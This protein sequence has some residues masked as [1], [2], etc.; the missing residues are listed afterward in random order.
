MG[1]HKDNFIDKNDNENG[2]NIHDGNDN[3]DY[4]CNNDS[5]NSHNT[6]EGHQTT[7]TDPSTKSHFHHNYQNKNE[8][9]PDNM[10]PP[11]ATATA[12]LV[13]ELEAQI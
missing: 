4:L 12:V 7:T 11:I 13:E 9:D 2:G 8:H 3:E 6:V 5:S 1:R 10:M